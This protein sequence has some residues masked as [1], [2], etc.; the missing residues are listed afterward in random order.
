MKNEKKF[1]KIQIKIVYPSE[2][3]GAILYEIF[4]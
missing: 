1:T 3:Y 4:P 2:W